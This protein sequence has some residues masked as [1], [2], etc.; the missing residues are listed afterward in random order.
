MFN[1]T[2]KSGLAALLGRL[3]LLPVI[4]LA[5]MGPGMPGGA[6]AQTD[7]E[8]SQADKAA[9]LRDLAQLAPEMQTTVTSHLAQ[10]GAESFAS[11][12]RFDLNHGAK[13]DHE[14]AALLGATPYQPGLEVDGS[15]GWR[16]AVYTRLE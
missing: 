15:G 8:P 14:D 7:G 5:I 11:F 10:Y 2:P 16:D 12:L 1:G 3:K 13:V 6:M 9:Y 4:F